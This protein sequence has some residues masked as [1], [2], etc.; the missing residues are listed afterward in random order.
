[1][2]ERHELKA[3]LQ[4]AVANEEFVVHYQPIVHLG[5]GQVVG[6]E[7]L[8][9][10]R[11]PGG[12]LLLPDSFIPLAEETGLINDIGALVLR[13]ACRDAREWCRPGPR[14]FSISVNLSG[15]QLSQPDLV[16]QVVAALR[17][18]AVP[19]ES[20]MLEITETMLM[21]DSPANV[22][23]LQD[24]RRLGVR[25]AIDDF[26]TGYSS[27]SYL[28]HFPIDVLKVAKP[29][30]DAL[31]GDAP[32]GAFTE[33]IVR[34]GQSLGV[35]LVAEGIVEESQRRSLESMGCQLGQGFLFAPAVDRVTFARLMARDGLTKSDEARVG[36]GW[37]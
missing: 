14:R 9:R 26:G 20:L 18:T 13:Q 11:P 7:A 1:V 17:Q 4:R 3:R 33:A 30:V 37:S 31:G 8:V 6:A 22:E 32:D 36:A 24:L 34:L 5:T 21:K 23:K 25:V 28:R 29:F 35:E 2:Q 27:M 10:W 19:A 16:D 15:R 12:E